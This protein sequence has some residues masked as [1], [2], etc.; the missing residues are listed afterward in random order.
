MPTLRYSDEIKSCP[1]GPLPI[2]LPFL[3]K[4][5]LREIVDSLVPTTN[6]ANISHG[7]VMTALVLNRLISPRAL[8]AIRDWSDSLSFGDALGINPNHLNDDRLIRTLEAIYPHSEKLQGTL[9]WQIMD[10]FPLDT[11]FFHWDMTSFFFEGSYPEDEQDPAASLIKRGRPKPQD[12]GKHRKQMQVGFATTSNEGI[13]F[14]YRTFNGNAAEVSQVADVMDA[15]RK[16]T[17]DKSFT[18][19]GDSKLLS[20]KNIDKAL[21]HG[22]YFLAPESRSSKRA[23]TYLPL[24]DKHSFQRLHVET[25][26]K[27]QPIYLGFETPVTLNISGKQQSF[28]RLFIVSSEERRAT[29]R[30]RERQQE[31][32][33]EGIAKA[34]RNLGRYSYTT[35]E[36]VAAKMDALLAK[37][38][39]RD[40][41]SYSIEGDD[42]DM[43]LMIHQDKEAFKQLRQMDGVY[44]LLTNLPETYGIESLLVRYKRQYLSEQ[45]FADLKGPLQLRPIFLKKNHRIVSLVSVVSIALMV[46]CLMEHVVRKSIKQK[47]TTIPDLYSR[48]PITEPTARRL[49][50]AFEFYAVAKKVTDKGTEYTAPSMN[51]LQ[52]QIL[53]HLDIKDPLNFLT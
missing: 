22:L 18:L 23:E 25:K 17:R 33:Y 39:L 44:T 41:I 6:R 50:G 4:I 11:S 13:P 27:K 42:K 26:G 29:R 8:Y 37:T 43:K 49:L 2:L 35:P 31:K 53:Y 45:R 1:L 46:Y 21:Q 20:E 16:V 19:I 38:D 47:Q 3:E 32:L 34:Q 40:V 14:W 24:R 30:S 52:Q 10:T 9:A 12:A 51:D 5:R 48:R 15:L 36:K 7:Q 28:R